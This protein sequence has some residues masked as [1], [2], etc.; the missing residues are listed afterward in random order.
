MYQLIICSLYV[1]KARAY[2]V[3]ESLISQVRQKIKGFYDIIIAK[4]VI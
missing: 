4:V 3:D 2:T 1:P